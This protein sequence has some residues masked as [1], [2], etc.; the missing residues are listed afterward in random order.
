MTWFGVKWPEK[1]WYTVKQNN[2]PINQ[3]FLGI[4]Y[5]EDLL[6][7]KFLIRK[8]SSLIWKYILSI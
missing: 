1:G 5:Y 3:I 7:F 8:K 6:L 2:Q 4:V